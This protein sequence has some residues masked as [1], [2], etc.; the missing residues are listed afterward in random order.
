MKIQVSGLSQGTYS[1]QFRVT[2]AALELD[3]RFQ[4]DV[5]VEA[6]LE[7]TPTQI[8]L[9]VDVKTEGSFDCDRCVTPF[10]LPL[11]GT[12]RSYYVWDGAE[13]EV[14]D[15]AEVQVIPPGLSLIDIT[16]DVRQT[17]LL[18]VPLKLLCHA[19]CRGL[20]PQ[21]GKNLN[22]ESCACTGDASDGRW[23]ALRVLRKSLS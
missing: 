23:E 4:S 8:F 10:T 11:K 18:S 7:K 5:T 19:G 20:C 9:R 21:C 16:E 2:P 1:Y 13:A 17:A 22:K 12:Y 6:S 15:P 3:G 14:L